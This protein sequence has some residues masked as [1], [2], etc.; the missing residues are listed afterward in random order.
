MIT[1]KTIKSK[2]T[3]FF[4]TRFQVFNFLFSF[5]ALGLVLSPSLFTQEDAPV[6]QF[7]DQGKTRTVT[8]KKLT[9][10]RYVFNQG[11]PKKITIA[12]LDWPPYIGHNICRQGWVQQLTIAILASLNYE[13]TSTFYPW[14]RAVLMTESGRAAIL[15]P[16][17]FIEP[18]A[19][20]DIYPGHFRREFLSLSRPF[21]GGP[22]AFLKR[23]NEKDKFHGDLHNLKGV[24]IGVVRGYQNTPEFD[25]LLDQGFFA[26]SEA[27]TDLLNVKKLLAK[28]VD[29]I[30]GDP[31]VIFY[32]IYNNPEWTSTQSKAEAQA[33]EVVKPILKYNRFY[34][35]V[36]KKQPGWQ[37]LVKQLNAKLDEF[38]S[39]GK[40]SAI[41]KH[42]QTACGKIKIKNPSDNSHPG[43]D[44]T[45]K[46]GN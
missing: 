19:P 23:K 31:N 17:Y 5:L 13:V 24:R 7:R 22:I 35:A 37:A 27:T 38:E 46:C 16:E 32:T 3:F 42:T 10:F 8:G 2:K 21:P 1:K 30:I 6:V 20:S 39:S 41:V 40:L 26:A 4:Q 11:A 25:R 14:A 28:R 34:F 45:E 9:E 18:E 29:L 12:T 44:Y 33:I 43:S 36:S 15:Y